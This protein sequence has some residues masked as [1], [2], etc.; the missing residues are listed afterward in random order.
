MKISRRE[1]LA[2]SSA[3]LAG[4]A[5]AGEPIDP[6]T[7]LGVIEYSFSARRAAEKPRYGTDLV[8]F[9]EYVHRLGAGG[10]QIGLGIRDDREAKRLRDRARELGLYLEGSLRLP[11]NK[12]DLDRFDAEIRTAKACGAT[13]ARTVALSGRRY[14]IFDSADAFRAFAEAAK[15]SLELALPIVSKHDFRLALENHKDWRIDE[16]TALLRRFDSHRLG[17]NLDFGNN[18]ALLDDPLIVVSAL[19]PWTFS[20]H[21]KDVGLEESADGFLMNE[22]PLGRGMLDLPA[23]IRE[24]RVAR[25]EAR[26]SLEMITRDPLKIPCLTPRY[27]STLADVPGRDLARTLATVRERPYRPALPKVSDLSPGDKLAIEEKNVRE[28]L[29]Y[30]R[31]RLGLKCSDHAK[32]PP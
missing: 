20:T 11:R 8:P 27:W 32:S 15:R 19:A 1:M 14:E 2:G 10:L 31:D 5:I 24:I 30:A 21:V 25:P 13:L 22:V 28:S 26:F 17:V 23:I 9:M 12:A 16:M 29:E 3:V 4:A 6:K 18:I 7:V